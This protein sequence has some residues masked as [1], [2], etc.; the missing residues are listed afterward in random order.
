MA[1]NCPAVKISGVEHDAFK[2]VS[3]FF[4]CWLFSGA[5]PDWQQLVCVLLKIERRLF[6]V[7][8]LLV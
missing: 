2:E 3:M 4:G 6:V 7:A 8:V 1:Q 5:C